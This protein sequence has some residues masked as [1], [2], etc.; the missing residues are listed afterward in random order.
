MIL[1]IRHPTPLTIRRRP[2][3]PI[4]LKPHIIKVPAFT[5]RDNQLRRE[6][7]WNI[8]RMRLGI[9]WF[10]RN[11]SHR[12]T[13][14]IGDDDTE[15]ELVADAVL[16]TLVLGD[17]GHAPALRVAFRVDDGVRGEAED[18]IFARDGDAAFVGVAGGAAA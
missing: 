17:V 2:L 5:L 9:Q 15:G 11:L 13:L 12:S 10:L 18:T 3:R 7:A 8:Q 16:V 4:I 6:V 1:I 14:R